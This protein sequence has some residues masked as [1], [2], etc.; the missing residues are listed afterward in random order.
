[1]KPRALI[2]GFVVTFVLSLGLD[3][4]LHLAGVYP[5]WSQPMESPALNALALSYRM[6]FDGL[7]SYIAARMATDAPMKHA[8]TLGVIGFVLCILG[9]IGA[10]AAKMG[11]LWYPTALAASVL[12]TAWIGG[13]LAMQ[14]RA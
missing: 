1:V 4:I 5:P 7:G 10:A 8:M 2:V 12:P 9:A 11:P 6:V 14:R 3:E 13:R